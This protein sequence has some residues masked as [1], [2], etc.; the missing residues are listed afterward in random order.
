MNQG[1]IPVD[2][3]GSD[4][5]YVNLTLK[6][7]AVESGPNL[8]HY[9]SNSAAVRIFVQICT[10]SARLRIVVGP[11]ARAASRPPVNKHST[12]SQPEAGQAVGAAAILL[13]WIPVVARLRSLFTLV[14]R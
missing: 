7:R 6:H 12:R 4:P 11:G 3:K 10:P 8:C 13:L 14:W 5:K 2:K 1:S 9:L